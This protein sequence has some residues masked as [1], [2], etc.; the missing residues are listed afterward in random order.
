L[1]HTN[2]PVIPAGAR[3]AEFAAKMLQHKNLSL[4]YS[5]RY[6]HADLSSDLVKQLQ[7]LK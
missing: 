6:G 2:D 1:C 4:I 5:P 7:S 3:M